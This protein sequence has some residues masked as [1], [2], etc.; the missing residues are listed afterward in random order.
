MGKPAVGRFAPDFTMMSSDGRTVTLSQFRSKERVLLAFFPM[1]FTST[2]TAEMLAFTEEYA[3]YTAA[4]VR[5]FG[6]SVD[7]VPTLQE[8]K[9][10]HGLGVELLSDFRRD[11]CRAY[12]T[13]NEEH[14]CSNRAYFQVDQIGII[15]WAFV[16]PNPGICRSNSEIMG[17]IGSS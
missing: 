2:C 16:E 1:A 8:F 6:I 3:L 9:N 13:L 12:G 7:S 4:G 17:A 11:V 5:V 14:F 15:R 10:K